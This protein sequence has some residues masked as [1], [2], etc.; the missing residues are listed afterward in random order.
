M[1]NSHPDTNS[2]PPQD[3]TGKPVQQYPDTEYSNT[4]AQP[5]GPYAA[6]THP[7]AQH[8]YGQSQKSSKAPMIAGFLSV[9]VLVLAAAL[10]WVLLSGD[11]SDGSANADNA[12]GE[13]PV[14]VTEIVDE[15]GNPITEED[16]DQEAGQ[17]EDASEGR[18]DSVNLPDGAEA[19]NDAARNNEPT[20]NFNSVW[21]GT[22]VT[23]PEFS[24]AVRDAYA[25]HYVDTQ[26]LEATLDVESPVTGETYS[27]RCSDNG[28]YVTC[29]GGN[30]AVVYIA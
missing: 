9:I 11:E 15:N 19:V 6:Q 5:A 27:M 2:F 1:G 26:E 17:E 13:E 24:Q 14:I 22:E 12:G 3:G 30:D 23:S 7:E 16:A 25:Q 20:G 18:P 28:D 10:A 29:T 4:H 21:R 8:E